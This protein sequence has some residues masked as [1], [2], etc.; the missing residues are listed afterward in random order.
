MPFTNSRKKDVLDFLYSGSSLTPPAS[1][2][3][4][5]ST[6]TP[7][8]AG[9]SFTEPSGNGYS[10]VS[11]TPNTTNF[12]AST[13][14]NPTVKSNGTEIAFP[15]ASGSWGT[16]THFGIFSAATGGTL[17]DW[18]PLTT[19]KAIGSGDTAKFAPGA[20]QT[21]LQDA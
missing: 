10:R 8:S 11:V 5:L 15:E 1:V 7:T 2:H 9:A 19:S 12:P 17:L 13:A 3:V 6:T 18:A 16:V 4:A 21:R 20:L 14:A